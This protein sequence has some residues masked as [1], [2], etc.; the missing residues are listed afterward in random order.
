MNDI[1]RCSYI[2]SNSLCTPTTQ[3]NICVSS[4]R[5]EDGINCLNL[6]LV[7]V[8]NWLPATP[9]LNVNKCHHV[10]FRR[11]K[12]QIRDNVNFELNKFNIQVKLL[13]SISLL[14]STLSLFTSLRYCKRQCN[15]YFSY[16]VNC[17]AAIIENVS[18]SAV[19]LQ[20]ETFR[21]QFYC[22]CWTCLN[23]IYYAAVKNFSTSCDAAILK[24]VQRH[25]RC[26]N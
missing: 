10:I 6:E 16:K 22:C 4:P 2:S 23:V 18:T 24:T 9:L 26:S 14:F 11:R 17:H 8:S 5:L 21:R 1:V 12:Q 3:N 25:V 15:I 13:C 19:I 7:K 20:L